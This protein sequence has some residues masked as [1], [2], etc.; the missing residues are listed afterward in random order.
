VINSTYY[1]EK[2]MEIAKEVVAIK[3]RQ[4]RQKKVLTK[5]FKKIKDAHTRV[6][7][8]RDEV[9]ALT[10]L[11]NQIDNGI[12]Q[13][14]KKTC[15]EHHTRLHSKCLNIMKKMIEEIRVI[16]E[17][18]VS[19]TLRV[20]EDQDLVQKIQGGLLASQFSMMREITKARSSSMD[21]NR[22]YTYK[23]HSIAR[24]DD[25]PFNI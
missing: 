17:E 15:V 4:N 19:V 22:I 16:K 11:E 10:K 2:H 20:S 23:D 12:V 24:E 21:S 1:S 13:C 7:K 18:V 25:S 5:G 6:I 3:K 9:D 14:D 8:I